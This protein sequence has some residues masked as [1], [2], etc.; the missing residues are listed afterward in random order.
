MPGYGAPKYTD[1]LVSFQFGA[2]DRAIE[3]RFIRAFDDAG[4]G[5]FTRTPD[6]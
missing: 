2:G 1:G 3:L 5:R 6:K 4:D